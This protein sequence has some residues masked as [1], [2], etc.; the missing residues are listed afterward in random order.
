MR[1]TIAARTLWTVIV[2]LFSL[3][4]QGVS[5]ASSIESQLRAHTQELLDAIAPGK[6]DVWRRLLLDDP[7]AIALDEKKLCAFEGVYELTPDVKTTIRCKPAQL[8]SERTGRTAAVYK[9]E[10]ADVFFSPGQPR[11]RRIFQRDASGAAI[12]FVDRREGRDIV[13]RKAR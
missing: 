5:P 6:V 2:T 11:V 8:V 3:S 10:T 1:F 9:P 13:W 7:P 12:R 4:V